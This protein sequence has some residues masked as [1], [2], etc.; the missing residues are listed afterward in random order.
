MLKDITLG[1]FF[2]GTT[3][4]P[5]LDPRTKLLSVIFY[6]GA[7]FTAESYASYAFMFLILA[8][9]VGLSRIRPIALLSGPE[10]LIFVLVLTGLLNLLYTD[11]AR[12]WPFW[13]FRITYEGVRTAVFMMIES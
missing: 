6:I 3:V 5:R 4:V 2:P 8:L 7:L 12:F 10:A 1:Q 13:I 9:C 11:G